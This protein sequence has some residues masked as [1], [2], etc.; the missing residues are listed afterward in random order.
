MNELHPDSWC[1]AFAEHA[2]VHEFCE[3]HQIGWCR[4]CDGGCPE[5]ASER[6]LAE[7]EDDALD[8]DGL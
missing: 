3:R 8:E 2:S 7:P 4:R 6:Q 1:A 5:C